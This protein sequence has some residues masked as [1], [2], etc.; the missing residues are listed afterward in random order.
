MPSRLALDSRVAVVTGSGQGIGRAIAETLTARG[1]R[2]V[3]NDL[4]AGRADRA[5]AQLREQGREA[6]AVAGDI[7]SQGTVDELFTQA[8][9]TFGGADILV[10]N[11]G[12]ALGRT[13]TDLTL[14]EWHDIIALNLTHQYACCRAAVPHMR[15]QGWG[16][17]VN[18]SSSAGRFRWSFP[19]AGAIAYSAAKAGVLGMTREMAYELAGSGILVNAVVPGN[20]LTEEGAKDLGAL[21]EERR[22]RLLRETMLGRFGKPEEVAG[23]VAFLASDAA[24]YVCGASL[25]VNGGWGVA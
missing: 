8:A 15:E 6:I 2:V 4:D 3:V 16:R 18:I 24:S 9:A 21:P 20:I 14:D 13:G 12:V 1:A 7:R 25:I 19:G 10:N 11:V 23:A 17:I 22:T 5:A